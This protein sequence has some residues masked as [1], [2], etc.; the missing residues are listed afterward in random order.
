MALVV[1][2]VVVAAAQVLGFNLVMINLSGPG[3][4]IKSQVVRADMSLIQAKVLYNVIMIYRATSDSV[5]SCAGF[6]VFSDALGNLKETIVEVLISP[7]RI[8]FRLYLYCFCTIH[9]YGHQCMQ[10]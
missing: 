8:L 5:P 1:V 10:V 3:S 6:Q 2:T 7:S 4:F 9:Q